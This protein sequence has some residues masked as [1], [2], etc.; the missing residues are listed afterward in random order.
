MRGIVR[1]IVVKGAASGLSKVLL[2]AD[3]SRL[4]L[5]AQRVGGLDENQLEAIHA[6]VL[7]RLQRTEAEG[8]EQRELLVQVA[9]EL[10]ASW[11][12]L[13]RGPSEKK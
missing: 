8:R 3:L 2:K 7:E 1:E 6:E 5:N 4:L 13:G 11:I 10:L 12:P 9:G